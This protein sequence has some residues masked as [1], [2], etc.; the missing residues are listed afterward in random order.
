MTVP[1]RSSTSRQ[2]STKRKG[3][4]AHRT[5]AQRKLGKATI[6]AVNHNVPTEEGL[7]GAENTRSESEVSGAL[8][9]L[10][11]A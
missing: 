6:P 3:M 1:Y 9:A 11:Y 2:Q 5:A 4:S 8:L 7:P 10:F